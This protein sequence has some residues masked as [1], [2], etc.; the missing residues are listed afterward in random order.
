MYSEETKLDENNASADLKV[1]KLKSYPLAIR[2]NSVY[3]TSKGPSINHVTGGGVEFFLG[4]KRHGA[5]REG[6]DFFTFGR[7]V[8]VFHI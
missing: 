2:K 7:R 5:A 8:I 6:P 4:K 3:W 1:C